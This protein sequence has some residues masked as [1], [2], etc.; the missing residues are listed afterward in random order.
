MRILLPPSE[1]KR[2]GGRGKPLSEQSIASAWE[3]ARAPVL[4]ALTALCSSAEPTSAQAALLL[5]PSVTAQALRDNRAVL[6]A[7]TVVALSRYTGVLYEGLEVANFTPAQLRLARSSVLIFSGLFGVVSGGDRV[8]SYR[9]PAKAR[10]PDVGVLTSYWRPL[11]D[12]LVPPL[13]DR[14]LLIDLRSTDYRAMWV[15]RRGS[16]VATQLLPIRIVGRAPSGRRAV[17]SYSSKW[18]KGRLAA[19]L[20]LR[21][22][23]TGTVRNVEDVIDTWLELGGTDADLQP[24]TGELD[25]LE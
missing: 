16:A 20:L 23:A 22:S 17:I 10:L 7:P 12:D 13:L 15:P 19:A 18:H 21:H 4:T 14:G 6:T 25:L 2:P 5:P 24:R 9:V 1:A 3:A 8:P 11:L